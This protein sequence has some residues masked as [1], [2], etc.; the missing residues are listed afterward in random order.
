MRLSYFQIIIF[1]ENDMLK[2]CQAHI[3]ILAV[4]G[5]GETG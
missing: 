1:L 4:L 2:M 3:I 5:K